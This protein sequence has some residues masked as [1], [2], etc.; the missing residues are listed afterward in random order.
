MADERS[1]L[2]KISMDAKSGSATKANTET[3]AG[4]QMQQAQSE[5]RQTEPLTPSK[6]QR[7]SLPQRSDENF[8]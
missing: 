3:V 1:G 7:R 2:S 6:D 8:S 4:L 5:K